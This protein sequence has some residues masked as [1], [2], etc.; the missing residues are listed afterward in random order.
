[1]SQYGNYPPPPPKPQK[2]KKVKQGESQPRQVN[3]TQ[4]GIGCIAIILFG[5]VCIGVGI[6]IDKFLL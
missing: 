1:M 5:I 4:I 6:L 2:P 3:E